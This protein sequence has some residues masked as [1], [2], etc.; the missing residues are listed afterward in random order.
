VN[1]EFDTRAILIASLGAVTGTDVLRIR[2]FFDFEA[3]FSQSSEYIPTQE[4]ISVLIEAAFQDP[5]VTELLIMLSSDLPE[6]NPL[7]TTT[8][9]IYMKQMP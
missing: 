9:V 8:E 2:A 3:L 6:S 5:F 7:S 4:E 1:F